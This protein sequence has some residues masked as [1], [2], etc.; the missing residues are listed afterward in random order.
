M[1]IDVEF[2]MLDVGCWIGWVMSRPDLNLISD[3]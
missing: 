1:I 2:L 3:F